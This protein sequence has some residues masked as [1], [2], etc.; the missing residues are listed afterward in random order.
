MNIEELI[1]EAVSDARKIENPVDRAGTMVKIIDAMVNAGIRE[2]GTE[3][4]TKPAKTEKKKSTGKISN[5]TLEETPA[6]EP[7]K[8]VKEEAK[9]D[10]VPFY[11]S[12][13]EAQEKEALVPTPD[14]TTNDPAPESITKAEENVEPAAENGSFTSWEEPGATDYFAPEIEAISTAVNTLGEEVVNGI[15]S[16]LSDGLCQSMM[17]I[18][19][20]NIRGFAAAI[21]QEMLQDEQQSA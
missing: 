7:K 15:I 9:T 17:D 12:K 16:R 6:K 3:E 2:I 14:D 11:D 5:L 8:T 18:T 1:L 20:D 19:P 21:Q 10:E 13:T 4:K